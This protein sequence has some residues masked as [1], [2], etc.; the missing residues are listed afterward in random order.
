MPKS[1]KVKVTLYLQPWVAQRLKAN[2]N[3]SLFTENAI[4][5]YGKWIRPGPNNTDDDVKS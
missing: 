5:N 1:K 3:Q 2:S 4:I